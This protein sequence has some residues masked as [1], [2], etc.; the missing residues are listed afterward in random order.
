[1]KEWIVEVD[2]GMDF[3]SHD[4]SRRLRDTFRLDVNILVGIV[5]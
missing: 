2:F 1:M 5:R 3:S 4:R